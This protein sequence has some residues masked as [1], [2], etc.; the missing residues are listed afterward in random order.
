VEGELELAGRT[1]PISF[2]LSVADERRIT[3]TAT[4]K[5][6]NWGIKPFSALFGTLKVADAVE[7]AIDATLAHG[8]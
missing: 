8:D 2:E 5:Q 1:E 7:V 3:G 6:T 4:V